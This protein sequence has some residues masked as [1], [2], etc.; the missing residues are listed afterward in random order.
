MLF[1]LVQNLTLIGVANEDASVASAVTYSIFHIGGSIGP[2]I[3]TVLYSN[4]VTASLEGGAD[5]LLA[6]TEGYQAAFIGAGIT[7]LVAAVIGFTMIRG[8]KDELMPSWDSEDKG[9]YSHAH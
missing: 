4:G 8:T 5:Q 7:M 1:V 6:F 9:A 3:L 2:A